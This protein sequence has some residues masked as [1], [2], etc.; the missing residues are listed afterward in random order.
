MSVMYEYAGLD[1]LIAVVQLAPPSVLF[2]IN[3]GTA[4]YTTL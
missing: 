3:P 4:A 2:R 1:A